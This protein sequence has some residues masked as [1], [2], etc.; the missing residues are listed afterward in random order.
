MSKS[1][2][3][4]S[5]SLE[6]R[7]KRIVDGNKSECDTEYSQLDSACILGFHCGVVTNCIGLTQNYELHHAVNQVVGLVYFKGKPSLEDIKSKLNSV[8][9]FVNSSKGLGSFKDDKNEDMFLIYSVDDETNEI[10]KRVFDLAKEDYY[11]KKGETSASGLG[12]QPKLS[13]LEES[14]IYNH[15]AITKLKLC[16]RLSKTGNSN[17]AIE[18]LI[19]S[20]QKDCRGIKIHLDKSSFSTDAT[21]NNSSILETVYE[22]L[23]TPDDVLQMSDYLPQMTKKEKEEL[24]KKW[25]NKV[26]M[27]RMPLVFHM[28]HDR[29]SLPLDDGD[30][31]VDCLRLNLETYLY[32]H[33]NDTISKAIQILLQSVRNRL[34]L[35]KSNLMNCDLSSIEANELKSCTF[36]PS[37][38]G[39]FVPNVYRIPESKKPDYEQLKKIRGQL[40][41]TY[42]LPTH[43]PL[44]R[45]S[46]RVL[47]T[48]LKNTDQLAGYQC[49]VHT[50]IL[51][52]S[53]VKGGARNVLEGIYTYHHYKQ[54]NYNDSGWGC[55][56]RSLQ[57]IIS[58][59]KHQGYIYSP[60]VPLRAPKTAEGEDRTGP[61]REK[62]HKEGRV[63]THEEIQMV[64]VDVGDKQPSFIGSQKWIG[65]QEVC[66]VLNHLYNLD[67]KFISVSSGGELVY[68]ARDLGQHFAQQGTPIM[69]GGGVL[70]HTIIGVD[71]NEKNGDINYLILDPHYIGPEEIS[72][73]TKKGVGCGWKKN[74]FWDKSAFYN[75]CLPQVPNEI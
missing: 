56:Y 37:Q 15:S 43:R 12:E 3:Q 2:F 6:D 8:K 52:T 67:S 36:K 62:L 11:P 74:A 19:D 65:S 1:R 64:L 71:F 20:F 31:P 66:Y 48:E 34:E 63:P 50:S 30:H 24:L 55:A 7:I 25:Y 58:W 72:D 33:V 14:K 35:L 39:H 68:K 61:L 4:I 59:F 70:A 29:L 45:Y 26:K 53:N 57:T 42:L 38:L 54:Q 32:L 44:F 46:Q 5:K 9:E 47:N 17:A 23:D 75:L 28:E 22:T 27:Q 41:K 69:I 13:V 16:V 18:E 49:N 40:H 60:D 10:D 21:A 73:I 51:E